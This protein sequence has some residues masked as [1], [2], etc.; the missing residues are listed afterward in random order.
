MDIYFPAE[1]GRWPTVV[2]VHGGSWMRGDKLEALMFANI[3]TSQGYLV[4]SVNY[5]L[6]PPA[7]FPAMIEDV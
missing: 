1:G 7:R 5:R 2:Y 6:Y 3:L 4:V